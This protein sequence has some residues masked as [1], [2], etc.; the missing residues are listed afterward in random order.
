MSKGMKAKT[1][2]LDADPPVVL[3]SADALVARHGTAF[4]VRFRGKRVP[5]VVKSGTRAPR[6]R[7]HVLSVAYMK[8]E[9]MTYHSLSM[10]VAADQAAEADIN[11]V[12]RNDDHK[13]SGAFFVELGLALLKSIGVTRVT[14]HD[15]AQARSD[16][17]E[18]PLSLYLLLKKGTTFYGK[19]GFLPTSDWSIAYD[20]D[21]ARTRRLCALTSRLQRMRVGEALGVMRRLAGAARAPTVKKLKAYDVLTDFETGV[22]YVTDST[23]YGAYTEDARKELADDWSKTRDDLLKYEG[24][25][26]R[27][28]VQTCTCVEFNALLRFFDT[29]PGC[30]EEHLAGGKT[31]TFSNKY[32]ALFHEF[33]LVLMGSSYALDMTK[34]AASGTCSG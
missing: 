14:L 27:E 34:P 17:C 12:N 24:V 29:F 7:I 21:A 25:T 4:N 22:S 8:T 11:Y 1:L 18:M 15:A 33:R 26:V 30:V 19:W 31:R 3:G 5:I 16:K 28:M 32:K 20:S 10:T 6:G 23:A 2:D 13:L 9:S